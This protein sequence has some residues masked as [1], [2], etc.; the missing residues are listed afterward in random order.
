MKYLFCHFTLQYHKVAQHE[1]S[2]LSLHT[3]VS[4]SSEAYGVFFFLFTLQY[5]KVAQHAVSYFPAVN[6]LVS[7]RC[8]FFYHFTLQWH[9][10]AQ[11]A[12]TFFQLL[13]SVSQSSAACGVFLFTS[14]FIV[15]KYCSM[16]C[17]FV[18]VT[19]QYHKVA[20]HAESFFSLHTSVTQSTAACSVF[21][22]TSHFSIT[23]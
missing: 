18:H 12:V 10:V 4:H 6:T 13:T 11:Q 21:V 20:L 16:Q 15:T 3:S 14:H 23:K 17:L 8:L 1:V 5:H 19:L 22:F 7:T 2:F 9:K